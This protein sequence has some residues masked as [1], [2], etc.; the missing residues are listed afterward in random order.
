M[1]SYCYLSIEELVRRCYVQGELHAWEEFVRRFH[2]LIAAVVIRCA[3]RMGNTSKE[4]IDDLIQETYLRFCA[5]NYRL[6]RTFEH[7]YPNAFIGFIKVVTSNVVRDH[8]KSAATEKHGS[9]RIDQISDGFVSTAADG[10]YGSPKIVE[11]NVLIEEIDRHLASCV[12]GADQD[13]NRKIFWLH[14]RVGLSA[15]DIAAMPAFGLTTKGVESQILRITRDVRQR[16][17]AKKSC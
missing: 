5:D 3:S 16:M 7:R 6:L 15:A 10:G 14:Y 1:E 11:R 17:T 9:N 2:R 8:F 12:T 4:T 13:R